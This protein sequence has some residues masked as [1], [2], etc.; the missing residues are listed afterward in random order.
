MLESG[1]AAQSANGPPIPTNGGSAEVTSSQATTTAQEPDLDSRPAAYWIEAGHD[2]GEEP[3]DNVADVWSCMHRFHIIRPFSM[4]PEVEPD[5]I[6]ECN[7]CFA[8]VK[9]SEP[10]QTAVSVCPY[11]QID[12]LRAPSPSFSDLSRAE[13]AWGC[14]LCN[15]LYCGICKER[16][17]K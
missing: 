3:T 2:F 4:F 1:V 11:A 12:G 6:M 9:P 15:V 13:M 17:A 10:C 5:T 8:K 16:M 14:V 7:H